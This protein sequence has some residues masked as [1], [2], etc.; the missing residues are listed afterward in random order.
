MS[1]GTLTYEPMAPN[2][3]NINAGALT[4]ILGQAAS[5]DVT[6]IFGGYIFK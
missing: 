2:K 4:A 1:T 5:N 6:V 3:I